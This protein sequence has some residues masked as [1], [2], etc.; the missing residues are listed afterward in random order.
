MI[1]IL[2]KTLLEKAGLPTLELSRKRAIL[3]EVFKSVNHLSPSFMWDLFIPKDTSY[4]LRMS[5]QLLLKQCRTTKYGLNSLSQCGAKLWNSLPN[6]MRNCKDLDIFKTYVH[7][8]TPQQG[9][10][11]SMCECM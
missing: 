10:K 11:C 2:H 1:L 3:I 7:Q 4:G 5:N 8:W 6:Y 9:C